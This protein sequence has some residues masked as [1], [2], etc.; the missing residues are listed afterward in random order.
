LKT[1]AQHMVEKLNK[2]I[3][4]LSLGADEIVHARYLELREELKIRF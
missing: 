2:A 4:Q 1:H 3:G